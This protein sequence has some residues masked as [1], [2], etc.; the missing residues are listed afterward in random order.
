MVQVTDKINDGKIKIEVSFN[1]AEIRE[2]LEQKL[3]V[4]NIRV[5]E[6]VIDELLL[7]LK[8]RVTNPEY[9]FKPIIGYQN[10]EISG[11]VIGCINPHYT[12]YSRKCGTFGWVNADSFDICKKMMKECE[13]FIKE[14]RIRKIRGPINF[15]KSLGGIGIQYTG[16]QEQMLYGVAFTDP[17]SKILEYLQALGYKKESEYT[18]VYVAQKTWNKGKKIDKDIIFR[19]YPLKELYNFIEDIKNLANNSLYQILP[20]SSGINRIHEF[21]DAFSKITKEFYKIKTDINPKNYSEIPQFIDTWQT[22]DLEKT[23][24]FAPMAF[25]KNTGELV[26]ILLG[27]PDLY[28][29][30][31]GGPITRANVDTAMVKKGYFGKGIFSALNNI[32]Q[33][34]CNLHGVNY[35]EGTTIWSNNSRAIDT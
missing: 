24:P 15:P 30:W 2:A 22:C 20:D 33:L 18:C 12:S 8:D 6:K 5:K 3:I 10:G 27:L 25:N 16:F 9:K 35:F 32:G 31:V 34:T 17:R 26:G 14:N 19:Y 28:E 7:Y 11:V 4:P 23:E 1:L 21:F 13:Q 29:S